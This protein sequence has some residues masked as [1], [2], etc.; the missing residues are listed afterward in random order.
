MR[1]GLCPCVTTRRLRAMATPLEHLDQDEPEQDDPGHDA[2]DRCYGYLEG[3]SPRRAATANGGPAFMVRGV[4]VAAAAAGPRSPR[5]FRLGGLQPLRA[6]T[7]RRRPPRETRDVLALVSP[8]SRLS[9]GRQWHATR[10]SRCRASALS[11]VSRGWAG[12]CQARDD[13]SSR[14]PPR[15]F[16]ISSSDLP[17]VSGAQMAPTTR[18]MVRNPSMRVPTNGTPRWARSVGNT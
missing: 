14:A 16:S 17:W 13:A 7:A 6:A 4:F 5:R 2:T 8:R 10:M 1:S 3:H 12:R 18:A 9:E 11:A 15:S